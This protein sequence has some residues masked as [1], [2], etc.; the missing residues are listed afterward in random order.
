MRMLSSI[1]KWK[2]IPYR[3]LLSSNCPWT[4]E[5]A[6][7][8]MKLERMLWGVALLSGLVVVFLSANFWVGSGSS[9]TV[10]DIARS[11][12]LRIS[13]PGHER[14]LRRDTKWHV[15]IRWMR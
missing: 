10:V 6:G 5:K 15:R 1:T 12:C 8:E 14:R 11:K 7:N 2:A 3:A 13:S 4:Y 9:A